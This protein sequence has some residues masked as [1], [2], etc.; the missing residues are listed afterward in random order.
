MVVEMGAVGS[1]HSLS[2]LFGLDPF[3]KFL[4]IKRPTSF[5]LLI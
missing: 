5:F 3:N 4:I 2:S 1:T